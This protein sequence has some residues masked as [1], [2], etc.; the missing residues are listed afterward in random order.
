MMLVPY[1]YEYR[2]M[3]PDEGL[4]EEEYEQMM[5]EWWDKVR[6]EFAEIHFDVQK[7]QQ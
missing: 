6:E 3:T 4:T 5:R 2:Q 1:K 7:E